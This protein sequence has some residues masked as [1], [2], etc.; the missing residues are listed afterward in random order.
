VYGQGACRIQHLQWSPFLMPRLRVKSTNRSN[1]ALGGAGERFLEPS[2]PRASL[3]RRQDALAVFLGR[4]IGSMA[5][6]FAPSGLFYADFAS[7]ASGF[8]AGPVM[9]SVRCRLRVMC[10]RR[11]WWSCLTPPFPAKKI[12]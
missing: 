1:E 3:H 11:P 8:E 7:N 12:Y 10:R 5:N 2:L 6:W 9:M 4:A